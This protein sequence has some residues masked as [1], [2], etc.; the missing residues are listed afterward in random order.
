M[1]AGTNKPVI[2]DLA[3][4][5]GVFNQ[6]QPRSGVTRPSHVTQAARHLG[7]TSPKTVRTGET[8]GSEVLSCGN[9]HTPSGW[10]DWDQDWD[11]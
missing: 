10:E 4:Q 7:T 1:S 5:S 6:L 8:G 11:Q 9:T 3:D 2:T